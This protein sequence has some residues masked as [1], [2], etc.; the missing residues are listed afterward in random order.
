MSKRKPQITETS[1][2]GVLVNKVTTR[3]K[4]VKVKLDETGEIITA[5]PPDL[6]RNDF[7]M[8]GNRAMVKCVGK[9][10]RLVGWG[11]NM[12]GDQHI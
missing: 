2:F 4:Q 1:L 6:E 5:D 10:R 7:L 3:T 12:P 9:T 11:R 8:A